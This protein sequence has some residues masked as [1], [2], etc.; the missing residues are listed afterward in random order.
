MHIFKIK[1]KLP[2][3]EPV[4]NALI[5]NCD[6]IVGCAYTI[7][8]YVKIFEK[9]P[10]ITAYNVN[11]SKKNQQQLEN[12]LKIDL[13][14]CKLN[15]ELFPASDHLYVYNEYDGATCFDISQLTL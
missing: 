13:N 2:R 7:V 3:K 11:P 4:I 12:I 1:P 5:H 8:T 6:L 14:S 15:I 9:E 10:D